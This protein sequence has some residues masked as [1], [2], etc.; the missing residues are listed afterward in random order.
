MKRL[1]LPAKLAWLCIA[2]GLRA[3]L[4]QSPPVA[5]IDA[6]TD[7]YFGIKIVDP[8]R[9]LE[10]A[11]DPRTQA[12]MKGQAD[13]TRSA[14]DRIPGR[15]ALLADIEKYVDA[16]P[17]SVG[18]VR[19]IVGDLYFYQKT[20]ADQS[21]AKLYM[22]HDISGAE[23]LLV[24]TP[25]F[26]GPHGEPPAI[27][28]YEP[29]DDGRYVAL[30]ISQGG[31]EMATIHIVD[32][33]SGK[34]LD[35]QI[36]RCEFGA[37][38]W[39]PDNH[40][41]FYNRLKKLAPGEPEVEKYKDNRIF[42]HVIGTS[43]DQDVA[44][45]GRAI[46]P[47]VAMDAIDIPEVF[48]RSGCDFAIGIISHGVKIENTLYIAP[49]ASVTSAD[50]PWTKLCD[51]DADVS[52]LAAHGDDLYLQTHED[53]PRFKII[54]TKLSH[55]DLAHADVIVPQGQ[56]VLRGMTTAADALYVAEL[57]DGTR[58][59]LRVPYDGSL[60]R[61][62]PLPFEGNVGIARG[63]DRVPGVVL[64]L[65][66]WTKGARIAVYDPQSDQVLPTDLQPAGAFDN[67]PELVSVEVKAPSYD[68][69]MIP[70]SIIYK[71]GTPL[72]GKNP[73]AIT[74]YGGY[75]I[76]LDPTFNPASV[77]WIERGG[78]YAVAHVRG[79][80][81]EGEAWHMGAYKLTKPNV[82]RDLI[83]CSEYLIKK[84]YTSSAY[85]GIWG[86]SNGGITIGRAITERP[87]LFAAAQVRSG[88]LN[89]LRSEQEPNGPPNVPEFGSSRTLEGFEDLYAMDSYQHVRDGVKYPGVLLTTGIN[90]PRVAPCEPA[91]M[92]ARL[93]AATGSNK[94]VLLS[95]DYQG[96]HGI[97]ASK[98]QRNDM[99][100][101]MFS[102]FLWQFGDPA[103]QPQAAGQLKSD[104][105]YAT[106]GG[107]S[108][109]LDAFIPN[110]PGPFPVLIMVHGGGWSGGDKARDFIPIMEPLKAAHLTLFSINYRLSPKDKWPACYE[111]V[112][113]AIRWVKAHAKEYKGNPEKIAILGYSAG[114][115]LVTLAET[116]GG[117]N[118]RV[119]A[120]IGM[121]PPTDM[122]A[123]TER[124]G[125]L[126]PSAK[127]LLGVTDFDDKA[128]A[129]LNEMSA[130]NYV[131]PGLPPF[132]LLHGTVDK[133]VPYQQSINFQAK[134]K[135]AGVA[136][137]LI[138]IDNAPHDISKWEGL[139]PGFE[140]KLIGWLDGAFSHR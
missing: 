55:P 38:D 100:A 71:K 95:V 139:T 83:A 40:S 92:A 102:F 76:T 15:A 50:A 34:M 53:A 119:N 78:I 107:E 77:A 97:G 99:T 132:L 104:I 130:I 52:D 117:E 85:L 39:R 60:A 25:K 63:D 67:L 121:S 46:N 120:V 5:P 32:T 86:G 2:V 10:N 137:D 101:D 124:R 36:D 9:Y 98:K 1:N 31:S 80:G 13:Y 65:T 109:K 136:C 72:D 43:P 89:M 106:A 35:D 41:F 113:T 57:E 42:L 28:Y 133:S 47:N 108:L 90:D 23:T 61:R 4:A 116:R 126:S 94:P 75:G 54:H 82:W 134:L 56:S 26:A 44:V 111:D 105:E 93:Q 8:Y 3:T 45:F 84:K 30:G 59:V 138:T 69:A 115:E 127:A 112:Q 125:G 74:A 135:A 62:L 6:V 66:S 70:L 33:Q 91:K 27:N 64:G 122:V 19:R 7:D 11:A 110:G 24:D 48:V 114:G 73:T 16:A 118:V 128:K 87:D 51:V 18:S 14:L 17:S 88:C 22:R 12:W 103:F 49:L 123:D 68:G 58:S 20:A 81:E 96:G 21:I 140:A 131:K 79:G 37:V 29:S 129:L